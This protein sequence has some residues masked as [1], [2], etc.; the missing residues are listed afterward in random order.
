MT[1]RNALAI[2]S[3]ALATLAGSATAQTTVVHRQTTVSRVHGPLKVLPH[4]RHK[5]CHLYT[6]HH[7]TT[8]RCHYR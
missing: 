7:N 6:Y 4:H 3:L 8:R 1:I 5:V 2:G